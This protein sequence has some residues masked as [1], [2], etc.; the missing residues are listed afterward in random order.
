MSN[1]PKAITSPN[2]EHAEKPIIYKAYEFAK[3]SLGQDFVLVREYR[4]LYYLDGRISHEVLL[5]EAPFVQL[6]ETFNG[7]AS[8][9]GRLLNAFFNAPEPAKA[10]AR[11]IE[12]LYSLAVMIGGNHISKAV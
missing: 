7:Q 11:K 3:P 12:D 9:S 5:V 8:K 2:T 10:C 4:T 1:T 6:V